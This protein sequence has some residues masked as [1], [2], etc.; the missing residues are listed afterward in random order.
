MRLTWMCDLQ[1]QYSARRGFY[2]V[3]QPSD[4]LQ[5]SASSRSS[6]ATAGGLP[7]GFLKLDVGRARS[8]GIPC[9]THELTAL[10]GRLRSAA[11]DCLVLTEQVALPHEQCLQRSL[12]SAYHGRKICPD[13]RGPV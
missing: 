13:T 1:V 2:L 7:H 4:D 12:S 6:G 9:T 3:L 8:S 10:N 5:P 11:D